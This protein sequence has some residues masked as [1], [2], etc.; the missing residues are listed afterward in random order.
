MAR[1]VVRIAAAAAVPF[2]AL[3]APALVAAHTL[4]TTYTSRLPLAVYLIGAATT[5]ALSFAFV[6]LRD[7]RAEPPADSGRRMVPPAV[8]TTALRVIGL[9][10]WLW[11]VAQGLAGGESDADVGSLFLWVYGWVGIALVSALFA[12]VWHWLDPFS[13]LHDLAALALRTAR[14]EG[15]AAASYPERLGRWPATIGFLFFVWLELVLH[16]GLGRPLLFVVLGY[17]AYTLAMMALFGRDE[18]RSQGETFTVWFRVL[19]RLAPFH[20]ADEEGRLRRQGFA[21]GLLE[22]GWSVP[23][24]VL[25]GL[26]TGSILFDGIS[27]TVPWFGIFGYPPPPIATL[28]LLGFLAVI[29]VAALVVARLV[30]VNATGAGLLP[31][32]VGYLLAHYL[33]YLLIDGQRIVIAISDPLQTGADLFG[34]AFYT[35]WAGFDPGLVWTVQLASVVGGHMIGAWAGHVVAAR[36]LGPAA[37]DTRTLRLRQVPLAVIM[38]TLTTITLW[39]LGQ[40]IVTQA[41]PA[42]RIPAAI[43]AAA[44]G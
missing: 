22:G 17:T 3:A 39:S 5:V 36:D 37:R 19:N 33:T 44:D 28:Q 32:A 43:A 20:L 40:A 21:T 26:A 25:V 7:V 8:L 6:L 18:W 12:P 11:V 10:G 4:D 23:E 16:G 13:T 14:V 29:V 42:A 31:I 41:Q 34:T 35:P 1:H 9:A 30:G 24:I 38:V 27:Q 15:P 2:A